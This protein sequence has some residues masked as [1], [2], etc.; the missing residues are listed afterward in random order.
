M[1]RWLVSFL[2]ALLVIATLSVV[3]NA[4]LFSTGENGSKGRDGVIGYSV[5]VLLP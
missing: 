5:S 2:I 3:T 1:R 4:D